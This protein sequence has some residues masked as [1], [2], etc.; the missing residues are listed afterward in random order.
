MCVRSAVDTDSYTPTIRR[1][2]LMGVTNTIWITSYACVSSATRRLTMGG[3]DLPFGEY[4]SMSDCTSRHSD[5]N[6]PGAYCATIHHEITGEWP[7][8]KS[9]TDFYDDADAYL[10]TALEVRHERGLGTKA[11]D[12][13]AVQDSWAAIKGS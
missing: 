7:G 12:L 5:K 11:K 10:K 13:T 9:A 1:R 2:Y 3:P 8:E 4:D 6:D